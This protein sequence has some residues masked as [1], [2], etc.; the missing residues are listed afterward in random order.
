M[1]SRNQKLVDSPVTKWYQW[2]TQYDNNENPVGGSLVWYDKENEKNVFVDLPFSFALINDN[3]TCFKGYSESLKM[4]IWSNEVGNKNHEVVLKTK[5]DT[6]MKFKL[7]DYKINKEKV[8]SYGAKYNKVV[9]G[10]VQNEEGDFE[11]VGITF[12]GAALTGG[13]DSE[14]FEPEER[15]DGYFNFTKVAGKQKVITNYIT[16]ASDVV[17]KKGK[18][19]FFV[20]RFEVGQLIT[21]EDNNQL[22]ELNKK[23][24]EYHKYY[25][26]Q[27]TEE[28]PV[29][30]ADIDYTE[31]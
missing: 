9:Y 23:L 11:L 24:D 22:L 20:P 21:E 16:I 19:K 17:K 25:F 13:V 30:S 15:F 2:K 7:G 4:G 5:N 3:N 26:S 6:L 29:E 28:Q 31:A 18:T 8:E 10:A 14:N 12:S 27:K 1:A